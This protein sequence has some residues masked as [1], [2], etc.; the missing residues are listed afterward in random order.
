LWDQPAIAAAARLI[1]RA[2]GLGR[3]GP[4]QL[5]AAIAAVHCEAATREQTDWPQVL[6]L[7]T[8]LAGLDPSTAVR[9]NRAIALRHVAGP[10]EALAEVDQLG[11]ALDHYHLFH[12]TRAAL[13]RD[14]GRDAEAAASDAR[15]L[16]LTTNPGGADAAGRTPGRPVVGRFVRVRA[17]AGPSGPSPFVVEAEASPLGRQEEPTTCR[18]RAATI[19]WWTSTMLR[20]SRS[21]KASI[22]T[23]S[24][25]QQ[26]LSI[27]T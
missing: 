26:T 18:P 17:R 5:H 11:D 24:P 20:S 2:A 4:Y 14:L 21:G 10:A 3:P 8:L 23:S 1:E 15:A 25:I 22:D 13:L 9:L 16:E 7:Y 6:G 27:R 12:A 19:E